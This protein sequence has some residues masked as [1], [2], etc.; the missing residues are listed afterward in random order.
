MKSPPFLAER[1]SGACPKCQHLIRMTAR[2]YDALRCSCG[3]MLWT[4][5]PLRDGPLEL[6]SHP[7]FFKGH[8]GFDPA[9]SMK[10]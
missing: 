6:F 5:R 3:E 1:V 4:L 7:G 10:F 2:H 9:A 8:P